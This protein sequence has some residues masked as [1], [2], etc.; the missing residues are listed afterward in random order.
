MVTKCKNGHWYDP[1]VYRTCPHCKRNSEKL[2]L[3]L[4]DVEED[5][6]TISIAE[7]DVSLGE[8]LGQIVGESVSQGVN[9]DISFG[10]MGGVG[11][12][13]DDDRTISFG[14][15]G[16][17]AAIQPVAGWVVCLTGGERG[18]DYRLHSGKNFVGRG[19][20][21]DVVLVDDKSI[22]RDR[23][24]SITYDPK[25][26]TFYLSPEEGN[27][28]SL[29]GEVIEKAERLNG[30]DKITLGET[31]LLFIPYCKEERKWEAE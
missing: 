29:N 1:N 9:N 5:D 14:F 30:E 7:I 21:M 27:V 2:S 4:D 23:H 24:C 6:R 17:A 3:T 28:V 18:K 16:V 8:Q 26:N 22:S 15:F 25:G 20:S 31:E 11:G 12:D 19:T 13:D 10:N